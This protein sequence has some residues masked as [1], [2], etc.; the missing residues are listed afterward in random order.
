MKTSKLSA[1]VAA[2]L[3]A[4]TAMTLSAQ[5]LYF[6]VTGSTVAYSG[7]YT[8]SSA[9]VPPGGAI[10]KVMFLDVIGDTNAIITIFH[11]T[12]TVGQAKGI[13]ACLATNTWQGTD[14]TNF[15]VTSTNGFT[16][17]DTIVFVHSNGKVQ[18]ARIYNSF[19][20]TTNLVT[21]TKLS[22]T[23][24]VGDVVYKMTSQA[25][26]TVGKADTALN[27]LQ[28]TADNG[29]WFGPSGY[30]LLFDAVAGTNETVTIR[31]LSGEYVR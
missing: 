10:P 31:A 30:P 28:R 19:P 20:S 4:A 23:P 26:L 8:N 5:S 1:T 3:L 12:N 14:M 7:N 17:N 13:T 24:T 15:V 29:F 2:L 18:K 16:V 27:Q 9:V 11:V 6:G 25:T 22:P 21:W